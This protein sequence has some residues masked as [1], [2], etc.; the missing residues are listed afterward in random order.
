MQLALVAIM[1]YDE[2]F[3]LSAC[4]SKLNIYQ[5]MYDDERGVV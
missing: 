4:V 3:D 5:R 2:I 1:S